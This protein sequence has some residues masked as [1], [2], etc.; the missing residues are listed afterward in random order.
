[1]T[2]VTLKKYEPIP[3]GVYNLRVKSYAPK[4]SKDGHPYFVW[5]L[6]VLDPLPVSYTGKP[7]FN[8][9]TPAEL[10][11]D[12][13]LHKFLTLFGY[14]LEE[15]TD[16]DLDFFVNYE[17]R[18]LVGVRKKKD[19]RTVNTV[20]PPPAEEEGSAVVQ[21][22]EVLGIDFNKVG[23][24]NDNSTYTNTPTLPPTARARRRRL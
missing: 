14:V 20:S 2:V 16:A 24:A 1:M 12:N 15:G 23:E 4:E 19:G 13:A 11:R 9:L 17:F 18:A 3:V 10:V 8:F 22:P 5:V 6:S 7:V 21:E